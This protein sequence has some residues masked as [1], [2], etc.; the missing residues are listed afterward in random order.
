MSIQ[1]IRQTRDVQDLESLGNVGI[2][3]SEP[4]C[5]LRGRKLAIPGADEA[6]TGIWECSPGQFRRQVTRGE[7]MHILSGECTF[8]PDDG[9]PLHIR[10][11][12]TVLMSPNTNG[13]W[14]V[15]TTVRKVYT[16]V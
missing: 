11:G 12:D 9:E 10:A 16:L 7:V 14:N 3:L 1:H 15:K 13:I 2:P 4:A 6:Q 5:A 8:T